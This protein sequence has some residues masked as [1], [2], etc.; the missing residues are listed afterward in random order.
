VIPLLV[1]QPGSKLPSLAVVPGDFSDWILAGMGCEPAG[2]P[3]LR[4]QDGEMLPPAAQVGALVISGSGAMVTD[5]APWMRDCAAWLRDVVAAGRP[6]LGICFGHQL[7]AHALGGSV[8]DNP[9]GIEVGSVTTRL[10]AAG[11]S[12]VLFAGRPAEDRVQASHRQSV[13]ALPPGAV[14]L[15]ASDQDPHHAFRYGERA[16]GVQFHP[17]FDAT[18]VAAYEDYYAPQLAPDYRD[19]QRA[20][21]GESPLG[22]VVLRAFASVVAAAS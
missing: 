10:S 3:V 19:R 11:S 1:L 15:A 12:D 5:D 13:L 22:D 8:A 17:E 2:V 7:L 4:P 18:I 9:R 16:W 20:G 14:A 6:V 21:R